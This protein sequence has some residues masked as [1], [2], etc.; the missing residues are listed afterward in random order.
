MEDLPERL[1]RPGTLI[2]H[3]ELNAI[4]QCAAMARAVGCAL[5][6]VLSVHFVRL[7]PSSSRASPMSCHGTSPGD[8]HWM[9]S[10]E[11]SMAVFREAGV[12][13]EL[14]P[15]VTDSETAPAH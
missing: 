13:W 3:A 9:E 5:R 2:C 4:I 15:R 10:I 11:K 1:V 14:R 12:T 7:W 6:H 8:E